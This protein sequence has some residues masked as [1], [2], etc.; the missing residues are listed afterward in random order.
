LLQPPGTSARRASRG[1][2]WSRSACPHQTRRRLG[3]AAL[4]RHP[5]SS[6]TAARPSSGHQ[7]RCR[8]PAEKLTAPADST[9]S[10]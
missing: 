6:A 8:S 7:Q 1:G 3:C 9:L 2:C 10:A 5:D 4:A